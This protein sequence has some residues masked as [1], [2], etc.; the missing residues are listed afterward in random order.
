MKHHIRA[1]TCGLGLL[2]VAACGGKQT[3]ASK[4]AAA[5]DEARRKGVTI[6]AGEHGGHS[7]L[8]PA[9]ATEKD[10]A[11][12]PGMDHSTMTG[13]DHG[14]MPAMDHSKMDHSRM[15]GMDHSPM[16]HTQMDHSR[17][18]GMDHSNM[19]GM[20]HASP[21][22]APRVIAPPTS[23]TAISQAQPAATLRPDDFDAPAAAAVDEAAKT[24]APPAHHHHDANGEGS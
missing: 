18:T 8:P 2:A 19:A 17:M 15:P 22:T 21:P 16:N 5:F 9:A 12:M 20:H 7:G 13:M 3:M 14:A 24:A 1:L 4:S 11:A 6:A 10:H 23:T